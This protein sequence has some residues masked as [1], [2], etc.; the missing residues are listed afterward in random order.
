MTNL[1]QSIHMPDSVEATVRLLA[2]Q[3]FIADVGLSTSLFLALK[4]EKAIF[5]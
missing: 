1:A 5:L 4:M 3:D 2:E